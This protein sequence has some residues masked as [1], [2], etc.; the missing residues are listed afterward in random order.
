MSH[1]SVTRDAFGRAITGEVGVDAGR[2]LQAVSRI[3]TAETATADRSWDRIGTPQ[4]FIE[5]AGERARQ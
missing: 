3:V 5:T 2:S 1:V 4:M